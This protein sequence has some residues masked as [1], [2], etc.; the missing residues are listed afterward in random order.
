M[1]P[2]PVYTISATEINPVPNSVPTTLLSDSMQLESINHS[3]SPSVH[4][5][6]STSPIMYISKWRPVNP[7]ASKISQV[8]TMKAT[9]LYRS[10]FSG[11]WCINDI[12]GSAKFWVNSNPGLSLRWTQQCISNNSKYRSLFCLLHPGESS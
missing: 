1:V 6:I 5:N 9:E 3:C 11:C 10:L 2:V 7:T 12:C 8:L 4:K